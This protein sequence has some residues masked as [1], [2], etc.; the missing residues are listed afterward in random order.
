VE[1]ATKSDGDRLLLAKVRPDSTLAQTIAAVQ[2][3]ADTSQG[4][5]P[6]PETRM[7]VPI[8]NF[9]LTKDYEELLGKTVQCP[10]KKLS[11]QF[12]VM[13]RQLIQFKLNEK[14]AKLKAEA[15]AVTKSA[16]F[17]GHE[18]PQ[19]IFDKPFLILMERKGAANPYFAIWIDNPELLVPFTLEKAKP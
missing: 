1:I 14:G 11:G 5:P 19:L 3:R 16:I 12:F 4:K 6:E 9:R 13:V 2:A 15:V 8:L 10:N 17:V 7:E 18:S